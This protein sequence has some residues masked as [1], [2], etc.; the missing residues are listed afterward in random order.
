[1]LIVPLV[2]GGEVFALSA[3]WHGARA[4]GGAAAAVFAFIVTQTQLDYLQQLS[5]PCEA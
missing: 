3:L 5:Q 1:M 2:L 4:L